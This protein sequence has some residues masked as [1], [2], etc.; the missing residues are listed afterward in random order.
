MTAVDILELADRFTNRPEATSPRDVRFI[1]H[2]LFPEIL[3]GAEAFKALFPNRD[4][5]ID[6]WKRLYRKAGPAARHEEDG[7]FVPPVNPHS[8]KARRR[9]PRG[10]RKQ[11]IGAPAKPA[12]ETAQP[13][14]TQG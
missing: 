5:Q 13:V 10:R 4:W 9:R 2:G 3:Q 14:S 7:D 11:R 12:A 6:A 1:N 8:R